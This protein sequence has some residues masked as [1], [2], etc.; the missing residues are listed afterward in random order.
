MV[1]QPTPNRNAWIAYVAPFAAF[2]ILSSLESQIRQQVAGP[3]GYVASYSCKLAVVA[4]LLVYFRKAYPA[5]STG[6]IGFAV[7]AGMAGVVVW[8]VLCQAE[9]TQTATAWIPNW[10]MADKRAEFDPF[11]EVPDASIRMVVLLLRFTGLALLVPIMEEL[12]WRGFLAR[13]LV[14]PDFEKVPIGRFTP[15]A[16]A[17]TTVFFA[18][19][20]LRGELPAALLWGATINLLCMRTKNVWA[21]VVMHATT[22][23]LLGI[24]IVKTGAWAMW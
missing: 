24:Y 8:V 1:D 9:W 22:N 2:M 19:V 14:D 23:L 4:G 3:W 13:W 20:H 7:I 17:V 5:F 16:F 18:A 15:T 10:L 11:T 12:F 21:C 6:G